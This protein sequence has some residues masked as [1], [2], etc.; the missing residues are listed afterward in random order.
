MNS[1]TKYNGW[2]NEATWRVNLEVFSGIEWTEHLTVSDLEDFIEEYLF[3]HYDRSGS[4]GLLADF[5]R[6]YVRQA[7]LYEI[8]GYINEEIDLQREYEN[9]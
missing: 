8:V 1:N 7:N 4:G 2:T 5:A 3:V 6:A 9:E